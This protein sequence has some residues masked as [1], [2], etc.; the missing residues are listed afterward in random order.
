LE[1]VG[2][3]VARFFFNMQRAAVHCDF[4]LSLAKTQSNENPIFY[5]QYAHARICSIIRQL[6]DEGVSVPKFGEFDPSV[7]VEPAEIELL[8]KICALPDE[9]RAAAETLEPAKMTRYL[10][11]IAA[12]FHTF[13]NACRVKCEDESLM[14]ARLAL[15]SSAALVIRNVLRMLKVSAPES[16]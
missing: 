5:V 9:I 6:E 11:E 4:D 14:K 15:I 2:V 10:L 13:Y 16:M 7:L 12:L 8:K 3:D 1:E